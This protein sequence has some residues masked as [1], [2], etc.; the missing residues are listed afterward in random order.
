MT[1]VRA[2]VRRS[3]VR[4]MM[5]RRVGPDAL[6]VVFD[7]ERVVSGAGI[8]LVATLAQR[9]DRSP[10]GPAGAAAGDRPGP[11]SAGRN[12]IALIDAMLRG[13]DC[14]GDWSRFGRAGRGGCWA[15]GYRRP[16][17][18]GAFSRAFMFGHVRRLD[19]L[20]AESMTRAW[21]AAAGPGEGRV[22]VDS[23]HRCA[24]TPEEHSAE[25]SIVPNRG[26]RQSSPIASR[27]AR[28][29]NCNPLRPN[30]AQMTWSLGESR[31]APRRHA[32]LGDSAADPIGAPTSG[33]RQPRR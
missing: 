9:R 28:A 26:S 23:G 30:R 1:A 3:L 17:E 32:R 31:L 8:A 24:P 27:R 7:D 29:A 16:T 6:E 14:T 10:G 20:L 21:P 4:C 11:A 22:M 5:T 2:C 18:L 25:P 33:R 13:T 15:G 19:R 12:V